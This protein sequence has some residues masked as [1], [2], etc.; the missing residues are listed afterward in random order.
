[1]GEQDDEQARRIVGPVVGLEGQDAK[2]GDLAV[3]DLVENLPR[4]HVAL[5]VVAGSLQRGESCERPAGE[6][7][8]TEHGL[9]RGHQRVA[10]EERQEPGCSGGGN[11]VVGVVGVDQSERLHVQHGAVPGELNA[12]VLGGQGDVP[13]QRRLGLVRHLQ[14]VAIQGRAQHARLGDRKPQDA[15]MPRLLGRELHLE[16]DLAVSPGGLRIGPLAYDMQLSTEGA[17]GVGRN[18]LALVI[19]P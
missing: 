3:S 6:L 10:P 9:H 16:H 18:Q 5:G 17:I 13:T 14:G 7:G 19:G 1:M 12:A 11:D 4:L 8:R 15:G 2:L